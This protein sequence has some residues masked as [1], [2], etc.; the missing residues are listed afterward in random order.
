MHFKYLALAL[1][2]IISIYALI[3]A[4]ERA[5][6]LPWGAAS[7][8]P[9]YGLIA[10]GLTAI[11][12][13]N[14][15]GIAREISRRPFLVFG[16]FKIAEEERIGEESVAHRFYL[17]PNAPRQAKSETPSEVGARLFSEQGCAVCH[18][19]RGSGGTT[20]PALDGVGSRHDTEWMIAHFKD[21]QALVPGSAMPK[22]NLPEEQLRALSEYLATLK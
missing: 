19:L 18:Q 22:Y 11:V 10:L 9:Q 6:S 5:S 7:R 12:I 4:S 21:P 15:M 20:G 2:V 8:A 16:Q 14:V 13:M 3:T 1:L 17:S